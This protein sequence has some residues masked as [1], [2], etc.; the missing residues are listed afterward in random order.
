[1]SVCTRCFDS[2][3]RTV[4][5]ELQAGLCAL[6]EER[7]IYILC[8][9]VNI[10]VQPVPP[11]RFVCVC[12]CIRP[13]PLKARTLEIPLW[14]PVLAGLPPA[15]AQ[16]CRPVRLSAAR[17]ALVCASSDLFELISP[18]TP[19]HT[20]L[21]ASLLPAVCESAG[22]RRWQTHTPGGCRA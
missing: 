1:M 19:V 2:R 13:Q 10:G 7:G 4:S 15:G 16:P 20:L 21:P 11:A 17:Y 18:C 8:D 22:C 5:R 14:H 9:E 12:V 3:R 6:A